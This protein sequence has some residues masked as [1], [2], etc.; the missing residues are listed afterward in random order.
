MDLNADALL[1]KPDNAARFKIMKNE[2]PGIPECFLK[3]ALV[4]YLTDCIKYDGNKKKRGRKP[5]PLPV[6][7]EIK[8]AVSVK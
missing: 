8:G 3:N 2:H 7:S 1:E 4:F 5:K 6:V